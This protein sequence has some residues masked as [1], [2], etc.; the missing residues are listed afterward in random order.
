L[1]SSIPSRW[2]QEVGYE[3][4]AGE[5]KAKALDL[6]PGKLRKADL[7][8]AIQTAEG[9]TPCFQTAQN[10]CAQTNRTVKDA[11]ELVRQIHDRMP[12]ILDP[13]DYGTLAGPIGKARAPAA[14]S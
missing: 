8:R 5:R 3:H 12:V 14:S 4:E 11:N 9:N 1:K 13:G 2:K 6:K 7:I 10:D